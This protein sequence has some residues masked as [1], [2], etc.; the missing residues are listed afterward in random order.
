MPIKDIILG[1][2]EM[3]ATLQ[4]FAG[5]GESAAAEVLEAAIRALRTSERECEIRV[6]E[7]TICP[8][9]GAMIRMEN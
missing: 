3:R 1:M 4:Y 9:C 8:G 2:E 6:M 7:P 5:F